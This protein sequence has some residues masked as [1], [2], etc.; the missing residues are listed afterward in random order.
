M[1]C[2]VAS[3]L[4]GF[5][6]FLSSFVLASCANENL[7]PVPPAMNP[8]T[9]ESV[10]RDAAIFAAN[11]RLGTGVNLGNALEAPQEGDWGLV[12]E[13]SW[14]GVIA[15]AGFDSVRVPIRWSA[16]AGKE[17]PFKIDPDFLPRVD[18][19][20]EQA[21]SQ[22]LAVVL[23][24]HHYDEI[25][26]F[27][28]R[29]RERF[30]AIW[31]QI[32]EHFRDAPEAVYFELLNEPHD[33]LDRDRWNRLLRDGLAVIRPL[34]PERPVLLGP[35]H[36]NNIRWLEGLELPEED[37]HLIVTVHYYYPYEF[38]HQGADWMPPE[39]R[40]QRNV[41]W[42]GTTA[43]RRLIQ[44]DFDRAVAYGEQQ[45]RP[46]NLGEFGAYFT[47]DMESRVRWTRAVAEAARERGFSLHYWEFGAGFGLFDPG[48]GSWRMPLVE[49][50]LP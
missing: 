9:E 30:L 35:I 4:F 42:L 18:W 33:N 21:L 26:A 12:L 32:A 14:F 45:E 39:F 28:D 37:R 47:A 43:E 34:H 49:A 19:V 24:M 25:F 22:D 29:E 41:R 44:Q 50:V 23:N 5:T 15:E 40:N 13:E 10:D 31:R 46:L 11:A 38:T 20:V 16:H 6:L 48:E 27:P 1:A 17:P 2:R 3:S 8:S 36:W 7:E